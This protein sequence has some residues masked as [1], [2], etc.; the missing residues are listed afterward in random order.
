MTL[1]CLED[2]IE[3]DK[4]NFNSTKLYKELLYKSKMGIDNFK[5]NYG[6]SL[7]NLNVGDY[8]TAEKIYIILNN[9]NVYQYDLDRNIFQRVA[10]SC[11]NNAKKIAPHSLIVT[12]LRG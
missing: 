9:I 1:N 4:H 10:V 12:D 11:F 2:N 3:R 6:A 8:K 7:N 5:N